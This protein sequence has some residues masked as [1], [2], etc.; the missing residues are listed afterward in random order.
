MELERIDSE[1]ARLIVE[2]GRRQEDTI[3]LI[4]SEN[5][6]SQGV[7]TAMAC[8]VEFGGTV[9]DNRLNDK[10]AEGY[11]GRRHYG[12]C[13]VVDQVEQLAIDRAKAL[14]GAEHANVQP[15]SGTQANLA[16]YAAL[17]EVG[18]RV[19]GLDLAQGGHLSHGSRISLSGKL[20]SFGHYGVD[21]NTETLDYEALGRQAREFCP[22]MIVAG[23]SAYSRII[24]WAALRAIADEVGAL[25]MVDMAHIAGLVA[26][27]AHPSPIPYADVVTT[28]THKTLRGPRGG[29]ILSRSQY[30]RAIDRAVF[31][32]TQGGPFMHV[33]ASKAVCLKEASTP[34]FRIYAA[35]VVANARALARG[36]EKR[37]LRIVSGGTDNHLMLVDLRPVDISGAAAEA[38]LATVGITV[39]KN[40]LPFDPA[41]QQTTSGIRLGTPAVTTRGMGEAEMEQIADLI[42]TT[43]S[44]REDREWLSEARAR[45]LELCRAFPIPE[46]PLAVSARFAASTKTQ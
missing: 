44:K 20:Y 9:S 29:M 36:L 7:M 25:L 27:G 22:K 35:Q 23:A 4:A 12:G 30:A 18:D 39:N 6:A 26:G 13:E 40:L 17:L 41:P 2:E 3:K 19:L 10:Y 42:A 14:F 31:P 32:G 33:I 16:V 38:L 11:P 45:S 37:G 46:D 1:L 21:P 15:H 28:T 5:Y 34:E 43:L 24:D 8:P